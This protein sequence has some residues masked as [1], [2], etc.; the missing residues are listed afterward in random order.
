MASK[1]DDIRINSTLICIPLRKTFANGYNSLWSHNTYEL[2]ETDQQVMYL[3][4]QQQTQEY[5]V[6]QVQKDLR[7]VGI[8]SGDI[9]K[10]T[11]L[12]KERDFGRSRCFKKAKIENR[13]K[14]TDERT[15]MWEYREFRAQS[16]ENE[17]K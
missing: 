12:Q 4:C 6:H 15:R 13:Q 14:W 5:P 7:G 3:L 10:H 9:Q 16:T 8:A 11:P 2:A 17:T 1:G